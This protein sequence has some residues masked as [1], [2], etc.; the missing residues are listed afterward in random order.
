MPTLS[1]KT[2]KVIQEQQ[3]NECLSAIILCCLSVCACVQQ[4]VTTPR[5]TTGECYVSGNGG[6]LRLMLTQFRPQTSD[7]LL[8]LMVLGG[9][10]EWV[11]TAVGDQQY[12]EVVYPAWEL[13]R[14]A[15]KIEYGQDL[16]RCPADD[17]STADH[18]WCYECITSSCV[19]HGIRGRSHLKKKNKTL[20]L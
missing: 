15:D 16:N 12:T 8:E 10:D 1:R 20:I 5:T 7:G 3:T 14:R 6:N 9:V 17:E 11:D 4:Y 2:V 13:D 18:Q 19:Y